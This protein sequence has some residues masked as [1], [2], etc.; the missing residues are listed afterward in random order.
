M[1]L[2]TKIK[3]I[4][5]VIALL[6]ALASVFVGCIPAKLEKIVGTYKLI[7]DTNQKYEQET[8]DRIE[9]YGIESYLVITG[10]DYGYYVYKDNYSSVTCKEVSLSYAKN[11]DDEITSVTYSTGVSTDQ[12]SFNVN[13]QND[14][15]FLVASWPSASKLIDAFEKKYKKVSDATD[16][17]Y[18]KTLYPDMPVY[19]YAT[20]IY[21]G[22]YYAEIAT[23]NTNFADY[24]YKFYDVDVPGGS[25]TCYYALKSDK[26]PITERNLPLTFIRNESTS[27]PETMKIGEISFALENESPVRELTIPIQDVNADVKEYLYQFYDPDI[28]PDD[29]YEAY[30]LGLIEEYEKS[31][32]EKAE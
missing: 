30:F 22:M 16:L 7:T 28:N 12:H 1:K 31:L 26:T 2:S 21:D 11:D 6:A 20:Y 9:T 24:I 18:V 4:V 29:G 5:L 13:A 14:G 17:S 3:S 19:P 10:N 27:K 23:P 8:V 32:Q 15:T 25:A